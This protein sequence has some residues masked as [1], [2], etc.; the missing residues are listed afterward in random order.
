M[1]AVRTRGA[2]WMTGV[3]LGLYLLGPWVL[4][5]AAAAWQSRYPAVAWLTVP[6]TTVS[7]WVDSTNVIAGLDAVLTTGFDGSLFGKYV[8]A[9]LLL[10]GLFF[11]LAW[12]CFER[13]ASR[14][15]PSAPPRGRPLHW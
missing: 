10:G 5:L 6:V 8:W 15:V 4:S 12:L 1:I 2:G 11:G 13:Y 14:E 7:D 3:L 9:N